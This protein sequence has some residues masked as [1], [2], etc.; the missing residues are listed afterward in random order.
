MIGRLREEKRVGRWCASTTAP[1]RQ[2][3]NP[4]MSANCWPARCV[5]G[6]EDLRHLVMPLQMH[7][8]QL[9]EVKSGAGKAP[10]FVHVG[11]IEPRHP[12]PIAAPRLHDQLV[13]IKRQQA[14]TD[15]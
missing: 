6:A 5:R 8:R 11:V 10:M 12:K 2:T 3:S 1:I 4:R 13:A 7:V 14:R 9:G 15:I